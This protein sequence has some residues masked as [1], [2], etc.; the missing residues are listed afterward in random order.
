MLQTILQYNL[1]VR[2][3]PQGLRSL[4]MIALLLAGTF[5][6]QAQCD[7]IGWVAGTTPACGAKIIDL[8]S[9][10]LLKAVTGAEN[11]WAGKTI[12]YS[13]VPA[14]LPAG[15]NPDGLS[16]VGLTCVSDTL[17]CVAQFGHA[18]SPQNAY[19]ISFEA[20][21]YDP[22]TQL[23]TWTFSDGGTATGYSVQHTF[24][25]EGEFNVCLSVTDPYGCSTQTCQDV[26][27][28]DQ[29]PNWCG[30]DVEIT[31]VGTK[32]IGKLSPVVSNP[33]TVKSVKWFDHKT[34]TILAETTEFTASLP[35]NG[36]YYICAQYE[37][38]DPNDLSICTTTRC[39]GL[40]VA[41]LSCV[42][43]VL[44][45]PSAI[46]PSFFAPVCACNGL[47]YLN[48]CD[49][50][51]AGVSKWWTGECGQPAPGTCGADLDFKILDGSPTTGYEVRFYNL[52]SGQ[53][54]NMQLDFGDGS[55][56]WQGTQGDTVIDHHYT[57]GGIFRTNLS[58][59]KSNNCVSS[60]T[61]LL[62]T[63]AIN[64]S[65][66]KMP[67][68]TDYV[69]PGDANGDR[70]ANVY[71]LLNLGLGFYSSGVPRPFASSAWTPQFAP[72]WTN[73]TASGVNFKH[74]DCDGNGIVNDFDRNAIEQHYSPIDTGVVIC[75]GDV[76]ELWVKFAADTIDVD[77]NA[78]FPLQI[79]ADIMVGS[80]YQP[81]FDLYG[82]AFALQYPEFINHNPEVFYSSNSF[83]GFPTDILLLPKDNY[84]RFQL[85]MGFAR[86]YGQPV[87]GY[88]SIA[89]V[90]FTTDFIII[91]DI[92]D[93]TG[94]TTIPFTIPV[95]GLQAIGPDGKPIQIQG[96]VQDTLWLN[97]LES[98][99][100]RQNLLERQTLLY[101]NPTS[102]EVWLTT[103]SLTLETVDVF[104]ALGRLV[105]I[106][107]PKGQHST[108]L[109]TQGWLKGSYI[110]RIR[111]DKGIVSK[112]LLVE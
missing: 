100:T 6:A 62:V 20:D 31:A 30:Y 7:R 97:V 61:K 42:N 9:G 11:L 29:N 69:F 68:G 64:L 24:P 19:R 106:H 12:R 27:V 23:C 60:V 43:P 39:Q 56:I 96:A 66:D 108:R 22:A 73:T 88:G 94:S 67:I 83:F 53:Y 105:E 17:P 54:A 79:S 51:A 3:F 93:R 48:E 1:L 26:F 65:A 46:C 35:G 38:E 87:S 107:Q 37:I 16:V 76:P 102:A 45:D 109:N 72:N 112:R 74:I 40:T 25:H 59:W 111:T 32:L 50:I 90:N 52:S 41:P 55:P 70:K 92:I 75:T 36:T 10:A 71:D 82:L 4:S 84:D 15:C 85:D 77:P 21:I 81:V 47:T 98:T 80:P 101:P 33:G 2:Q 49:A 34:N 86:K 44:V 58:V 8:E 103:G 89:K 5:G 99:S 63:D 18:V 28:S 104:D 14:S 95:H 78:P 13:A 91:I 57:H 110:L